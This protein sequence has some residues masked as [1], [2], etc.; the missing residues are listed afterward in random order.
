ML[1]L[2]L[3]HN[4]VTG[5]LERNTSYSRLDSLRK[6]LLGMEQFKGGEHF[7]TFGVAVHELFLEEKKEEAFKGL[8][9]DDQKR[10]IAMVKS[11]NSHPVV[12]SLMDK[13]I[14]EEKQYGHLHGVEFAYIIDRKQLHLDRAFDL[15]TTTCKDQKDFEQKAID[16]G[17]PKQGYIYKTLSNVK[18]FY[19]IGIQKYPPFKVFVVGTDSPVWQAEEKYAA[20]EIE[21]LTYFYQK[22]GN[23]TGGKV[24][25]TSKP[26]IDLTM[27]GKQ[28]ID[29]MHK[30]FQLVM[31]HKKQIKKH[32]Q[33]MTRE[34]VKI[35]KLANKFPKQ[36]RPLYEGK[37]VKILGK[38]E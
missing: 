16:Y 2:L 27:N 31:E 4:I 6:Y 26:L 17:Y 5:P 11:L 13:G 22:Y 29:E 21:F 9:K 18:E 14:S 37:I 20:K 19:F 32:E 35:K 28:T 3:K 23:F 15:K 12:Q 36:D 33:G 10:V 25:E 24:I 1:Q 7:L 38:L 8:S 34:Q 30:H